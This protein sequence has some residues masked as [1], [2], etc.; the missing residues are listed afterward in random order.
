M[1][2]I[3]LHKFLPVDI[4]DD[5]F[6]AIKVK[7]ESKL[8]GGC[9]REMVLGHAPKDIDIA[10]QVLPKDVTHLLESEGYKCIPTGINYGTVTVIKDKYKFEVT[11]L[12]SDIRTYGRHAEVDFT[13]DWRLDAE[14]RDFT[15]NAL[16][17]SLD[18]RI[19]DFF[20][21]IA[22][23]ETRLLK[24]IGNPK[25]R[26]R[27]DYL[28]VLRY[29]RFYSY[30]N[31]NNIDQPSLDACAEL[32]PGLKH[33]SG[34]RIRIEIFKILSSPYANESC[35]LMQEYGVLKEIIQCNQKIDFSILHFCANPLVNLAAILKSSGL[36][37]HEIS[38]FMNTTKLFNVEKSTIAD[39]LWHIEEKLYSAKLD[40]LDHKAIIY[41]FGFEIYKN[42]ISLLQV[43]HPKA[44]ISAIDHFNPPKFPVRGSDLLKFGLAGKE[45]SSKMSELEKLWIESN[46]KL[47]KAELLENL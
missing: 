13:T 42:Y 11:T 15:F 28:R 34:E 5:L 8:V 23:L 2:T 40:Q 33:L 37:R 17:M 19:D 16:Y 3:A 7:G 29:F 12:R 38:T 32:A 10:T 24:F 26:I 27:E 18:G 45:I 44:T 4:L 43:L 20:N 9:V 30:Y 35:T 25:A 6:S 21:G 39:L 1:S 22:D 41:N 46:F 31:G 14:R 36:N 47:T